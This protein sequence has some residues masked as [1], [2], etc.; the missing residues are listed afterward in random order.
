MRHSL[1]V[2]V[3][4]GFGVSVVSEGKGIC[5]LSNAFPSCSFQL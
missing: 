1:D 3:G 2:H 5:A 4:S